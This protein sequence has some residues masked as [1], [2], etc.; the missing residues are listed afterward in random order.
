MTNPNILEMKLPD[1]VLIYRGQKYVEGVGRIMKVRRVVPVI[2]KF[3]FFTYKRTQIRGETF[4]FRPSQDLLKPLRESFTYIEY[5][6]NNN[7]LSNVWYKITLTD[8]SPGLL[9]GFPNT[10]LMY[11]YNWRRVKHK[12]EL[13]KKL[14]TLESENIL[15]F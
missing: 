6:N 1:Y 10:N 3:W 12:S 2:K 8:A 5:G 15:P 4:Y 13:W 11:L 9:Y 7:T 14:N